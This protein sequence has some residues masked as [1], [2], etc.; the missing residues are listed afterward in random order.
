MPECSDGVADHGVLDAVEE[1]LDVLWHQAA[2]ARFGLF[3]ENAL[4][5]NVMCRECL[6]HRR[7]GAFNHL[8]IVL[9][10][11][12]VLFILTISNSVLKPSW[13]RSMVL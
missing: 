11:F 1:R 9:A 4:C 5:V 6:R 3:A 10:C 7:F 13:Q 2:F 12:D 8:L